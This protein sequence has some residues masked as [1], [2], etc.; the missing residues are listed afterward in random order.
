MQRYWKM[1]RRLFANITSD[2]Q[3]TVDPLELELIGHYCPLLEY[4]SCVIPVMRHYSSGRRYAFFINNGTFEYRELAAEVDIVVHDGPTSRKL[5]DFECTKDKLFAFNSNVLVRFYAVNERQFLES[6]LRDT[7]LDNCRPFVRLSLARAANVP[8][9]VMRE[10]KGCLFE[11]QEKSREFAKFWYDSQRNQILTQLTRLAEKVTLPLTFEEF[12]ASPSL[13]AISAKN[14]PPE[15]SSAAATP[16]LGHVWDWACELVRSKQLRNAQLRVTVPSDNSALHEAPRLLSRL[17]INGTKEVRPPVP[18]H[19]ED[20]DAFYYRWHRLALIH[21]RRWYR[22]AP[23]DIAHNAVCKLLDPKK[24]YGRHVKRDI[25]SVISTECRYAASEITKTSQYRKRLPLSAAS[26]KLAYRL[27]ET[28]Y[29]WADLEQIEIAC[30]L[31]VFPA[32]YSRSALVSSEVL[33][34]CHGLT[35]LSKTERN[36]L[37]ARICEGKSF[38]EIAATT[39]KDLT[40]LYRIYYRTIRKL[41]RISKLNNGLE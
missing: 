19:Q 14:T 33:A 4:P 10:I 2:E 32:P 31:G 13:A 20:L 15:K 16:H 12:L 30:R 38:R 5:M 1:K 29:T 27:E 9:L 17:V 24:S 41:K 3:R 6:L 37:Y 23:E 21:C 34:L 18:R 11:L 40:E 7:R 8:E 28:P 22:W 36:V 26:E 39:N 25:R 35:S